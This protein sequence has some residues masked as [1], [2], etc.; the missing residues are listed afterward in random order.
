[1]RIAFWR[2]L[3]TEKQFFQAKISGAQ[4]AFYW[5]LK[6]FWRLT[7]KPRT[8][9][10]LLGLLAAALRILLICTIGFLPI[11][12]ARFIAP[13]LH[14]PDTQIA[15]LNKVAYIQTTI[16]VL[17]QVFKFLLDKA[18]AYRAEQKDQLRN[19]L[20]MSVALSQAV[21]VISQQIESYANS[22]A[23]AATRDQFLG[24]ALKCIEACVKLC[25]GNLKD[26]FCC[27]SL[28][29]FEANGNVKIR[30]RSSPAGRPVGGEYPQEETMAYVAA[31]YTTQS[32]AVHDFKR[33]AG[34]FSWKC[35]KYRGLS[36]PGKPPYSSILILPLPPTRVPGQNHAIRKGVVTIDAGRR[37][38]F[39]GR[40]TD[41]LPRVSAFL[42]L[43]NLM[44]NSHTSGVKLEP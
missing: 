28:L 19:L 25:T 43:I 33:A 26:R 29:T 22:A 40:D 9:I 44:L 5:L 21:A 16:L 17:A 36:L 13:Y 34:Q 11:I 6:L 15:S 30:A 3:P 32:V 37:Y 39:L 18:Q 24:D 41:I 31:R 8:Q 20:E 1:L 27:V 12:F 42:D 7:E 2:P 35:F 38:E 23:A 4:Y 14:L 10:S